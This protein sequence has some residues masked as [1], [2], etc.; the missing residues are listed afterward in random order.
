MCGAFHRK[1]HKAEAHFSNDI[2]A[3]MSFFPRPGA[4]LERGTVASR[5]RAQAEMRACLAPVGGVEAE[6]HR[7]TG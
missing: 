2:N 6:A 7:L 1:V 5:T 3:P 4:R